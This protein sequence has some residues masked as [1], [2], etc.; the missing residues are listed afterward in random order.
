VKVF[1]DTNLFIDILLNREPFAENSALIYKLCENNMLEGYVAPITLNNIYYICR[2][3]KH[4]EN[5]KGYLLD[6][7]TVFTVAVLDSE[8]VKKA[9]R[10]KINDYEDALQYAM[11]SQNTCEYLI[12]RNT[13]D[14][15]NMDTL[16]VVTPETFLE[17]MNI[18]SDS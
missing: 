10:Y 12:T 11:A 9:N 2:K 17:K 18:F 3:A 4:I 6:I 1:V 14:F 16:K 13:K 15:K 7:S 8:S 5:I